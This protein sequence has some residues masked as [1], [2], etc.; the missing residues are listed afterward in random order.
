MQGHELSHE[1]LSNNFMGFFAP[2]SVPAALIN[3][4]PHR[5]AP[6]KIYSPAA[7][8]KITACVV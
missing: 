2:A 1:S 3:I 8:A 6:W 5:R 4:K 7:V